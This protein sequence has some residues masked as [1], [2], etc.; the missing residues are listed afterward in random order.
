MT[1]AIACLKQTVL[2]YIRAMACTHAPDELRTRITLKQCSLL[3]VLYTCPVAGFVL[4][5]ECLFI[6][7]YK[8]QS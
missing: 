4:V 7:S 2:T 6:S 8:Q 1:G 3:R 5:G